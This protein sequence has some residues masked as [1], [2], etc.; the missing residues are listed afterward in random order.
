ME[1]EESFGVIP[2]KKDPLGWR[3]FLIQQKRGEHWGF[4]KGHAFAG[5]GAQ[6]TAF[7]ELKEETNFD[8]LTCIRL[9]PLIEKY[10]CVKLGK[11]ISKTVFYFLCE[12]KGRM[13]LQEEE[14]LQGRWC[15]IV[16]AYHLATYS[17]VKNVIQQASRVLGV[18][19]RVE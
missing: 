16:S 18:E 4:P 19:L 15:D 6:E 14:I 2:L 8:V 3:L 10:T 9:D 12:V 1:L 11:T 5:E 17:E 7:R 13:S